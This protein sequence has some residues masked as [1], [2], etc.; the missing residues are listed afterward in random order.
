M[1]CDTTHSI[2]SSTRSEGGTATKGPR[3]DSNPLKANGTLLTLL[4]TISSSSTPVH[5]SCTRSGLSSVHGRCIIFSQQQKE[6]QR[7]K[8]SAP[9]SKKNRTFS[10]FEERLARNVRR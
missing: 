1:S 3:G 10:I 7:T 2:T 5:R 8:K 4:L 6:L 9:S